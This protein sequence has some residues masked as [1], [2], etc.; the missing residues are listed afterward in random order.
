MTTEEI[1]EKVNQDMRKYFA[2]AKLEAKTEEEVQ[3]I[4]RGEIEYEMERLLVDEFLPSI[5]AKVASHGGGYM[6]E[7]G[8]HGSSIAFELKG[9]RFILVIPE[10][11]HFDWIW[12]SND[13]LEELD[14][15][16]EQQ[17]LTDTSPNLEGALDMPSSELRKAM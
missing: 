13:Y 6:G 2:E 8:I 7:G 9:H 14:R 5:G 3:Q 1:K 4:E 15:R 10:A 11:G 16:E 12:R 17:A